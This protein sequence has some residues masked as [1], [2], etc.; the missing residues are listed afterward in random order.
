[1]NE[2]ISVKDRL[3]EDDNFE[4]VICD[5]AGTWHCESL[6]LGYCEHRGAHKKSSE[7]NLTRCAGRQV[8]C[9]PLKEQ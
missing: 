6:G 4:K 9:I 2:W 5:H 1:M 8:K 3:S 7:C